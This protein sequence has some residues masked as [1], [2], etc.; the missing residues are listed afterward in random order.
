MPKTPV[1]VVTVVI[2]VVVGS[3]SPDLFTDFGDW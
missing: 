2:V 3:V 1:P